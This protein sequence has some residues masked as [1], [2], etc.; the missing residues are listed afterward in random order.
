MIF[1]FAHYHI[2]ID[3]L[4]FN[5]FIPEGSERSDTMG[6]GASREGEELVDDNYV[7]QSQTGPASGPHSPR[8]RGERRHVSSRSSMKQSS[9]SSMSRNVGKSLFSIF[10]PETHCLLKSHTGEFQDEKIK[11]LKLPIECDLYDIDLTYSILTISHLVLKLS[12]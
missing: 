1:S 2:K 4:S 12:T 5:H 7:T 11:I 3:K 9:R 8:Q 10:L 6:T